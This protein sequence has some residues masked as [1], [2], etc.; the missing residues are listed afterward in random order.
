MARQLKQT[1]MMTESDLSSS[2]ALSEQEEPDCKGA[3]NFEEDLECSVSACCESI[4]ELKIT[5]MADD[6]KMVEVE[7][8]GLDR[9]DAALPT[10]DIE[11]NVDTKVEAIHS[12]P[13]PT[14]WQKLRSFLGMAMVSP[15]FLP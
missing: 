15:C 5:R 2:L 6:I 12:F 14:T 3:V 1:E 13:E 7:R 4:S 10:V 8:T 11:V 9:P